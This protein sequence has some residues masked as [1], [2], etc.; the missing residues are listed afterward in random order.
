MNFFSRPY[1][2]SPQGLVYPHREQKSQWK[3][4]ENGK[5]ALHW[6][7]NMILIF[8]VLWTL[9]KWVWKSHLGYNNHHFLLGCNSLDCNQ[10]RRHGCNGLLIIFKKLA[11]VYVNCNNFS[12][13]SK[14]KVELLEISF[15]FCFMAILPGLAWFG[16]KAI[17]PRVMAKVMAILIVITTNVKVKF[18][19]YVQGNVVLLQ[20]TWS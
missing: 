18:F 3:I 7:N 12:M 19:W 15:K 4:P 8:S 20:A 9:L 13:H 2:I 17:R 16:L 6:V 14:L 10:L 11:I 5:C 1:K